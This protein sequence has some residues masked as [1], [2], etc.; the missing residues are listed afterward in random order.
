M[1]RGWLK[2]LCDGFGFAVRV[3]VKYAPP[4]SQ[5]CP[6]AAVENLQIKR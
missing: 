4:E 5:T 2:V 3:F 1:N 6:L